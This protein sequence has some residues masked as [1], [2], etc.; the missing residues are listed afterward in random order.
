AALSAPTHATRM[1]ALCGLLLTKD[2]EPRKRLV[3]KALSAKNPEVEP[4]MQRAQSR[5][6]SLVAEHQGV[7][8]VDATM[9]LLRLAGAVLQRY[10]D[11][12]VR[13]AALDFE[14]LIQHAQNLLA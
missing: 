2:L 14:D 8:L 6:L 3:T 10:T 11:A 9:A 13:R 4:M 7:S 5:L 12:K 1:R